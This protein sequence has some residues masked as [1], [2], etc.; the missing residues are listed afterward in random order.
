MKKQ[1]KGK[2]IKKKLIDKID[3]M[4]RQPTDG[5]SLLFLVG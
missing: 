3:L 4:S 5:T 1:K 2:N